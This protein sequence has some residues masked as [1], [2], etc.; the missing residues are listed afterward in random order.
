MTSASQ[1][2]ERYKIF[3]KFNDINIFFKENLIRIGKKHVEEFW[4]GYKF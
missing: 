1:N 3:I 4:H 2:G